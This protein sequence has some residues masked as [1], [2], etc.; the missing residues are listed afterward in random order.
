MQQE[1]HHGQ[2]CDQN[3]PFSVIC[4]L[5]KVLCHGDGKLT[6]QRDIGPST[7]DKN[8]TVN[9]INSTCS[10]QH[11]TYS[12]MYWLRY[13]QHLKAVSPPEYHLTLYNSKLILRFLGPVWWTHSAQPGWGAEASLGF[14]V[15][16]LL[17]STY[18]T[19]EGL[20]NLKFYNTI[21]FQWTLKP[22][23]S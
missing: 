17:S 11:F 6:L 7:L 9:R 5:A 3:N 8:P 14:K 4:R 16:P 1:W 15:P 21:C 22:T 19:L 23:Q 13:F 10:P 18:P 20:W 2:H 12:L